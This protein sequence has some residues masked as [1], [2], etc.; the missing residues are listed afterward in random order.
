MTEPNP[1]PQSTPPI[2]PAGSSTAGSSTGDDRNL[3]MFCH[4]LGLC[5]LTSIPGAAIV[6]PLV[7]WLMKKDTS[8]AVDR[9]GKEAI[10]FNI[11]FF[12]YM[13]I[14]GVSVVAFIG[15]IL[16][17]VVIVTW[18]VLVIMASISTSKG[19]RYQYPLTIRFLK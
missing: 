11:S 17:P 12:I 16:L 4:L 18:L 14:A 15:F 13:A 19:E 2:E 6:G 7:L 5:G 3:G 1:Q 9:E 8:E 10:N